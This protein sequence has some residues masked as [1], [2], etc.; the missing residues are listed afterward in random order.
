MQI[1]FY[2]IDDN[3]IQEYKTWD[4][5][6]YIKKNFEETGIYL[7]FDMKKFYE[8]QSKNLPTSHFVLFLFNEKN[9]IVGYMYLYLNIERKYTEFFATAVD[10]LYRNKGYAREMIYKSLTFIESNNI[11]VI[12]VPLIKNKELNIYMLKNLFIQLIAEYSNLKFNIKYG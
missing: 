8:S 12:D 3:F 4:Y 2:E 1:K 7:Y 6:E 11:S 9:Q 10:L 5:T